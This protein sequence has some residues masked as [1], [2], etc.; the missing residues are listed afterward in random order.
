MSVTSHDARPHRRED[1]FLAGAS[2]LAITR[3]ST[4]APRSRWLPGRRPAAAGPD[5]RRKGSPDRCHASLQGRRHGAESACQHAKAVRNRPRSDFDA[6]FYPGG[7]GPLWDLSV[8]KTSIDLIRTRTPGIRQAPRGEAAA[9]K[10]HFWLLFLQPKKVTRQRKP[11][12]R[13]EMVSGRRVMGF[14]NTEEEAV[15]LNWLP[16]FRSNGAA[17]KARH[18]FRDHLESTNSNVENRNEDPDRPHLPRQARPP[19]AQTGFWLEEFA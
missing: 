16:P 14:T 3:F 18:G 11:Q 17:C 10:A 1:R 4:P 7:H 5:Q 15:G 6:V 19:A 12:R 2:S 8:D 9:C 13:G